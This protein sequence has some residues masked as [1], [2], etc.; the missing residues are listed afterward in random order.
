[1]GGGPEIEIRVPYWFPIL[2]HPSTAQCD[3]YIIGIWKSS[4]VN[5]SHVGLR[6]VGRRDQLVLMFHPSTKE[7]NPLN[8]VEF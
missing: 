4:C 2:P 1:M 7:V 6:T 3:Q 8:P 5:K